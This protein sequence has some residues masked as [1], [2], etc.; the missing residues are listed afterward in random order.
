[1]EKGEVLDDFDL[2]IE[3]HGLIIAG[4]DTTA[5]T[6]SY[7]IWAVTSRPTLMKQLQDEVER[8]PTDFSEAH[9]EQLPILNA[10]IEET[11]RLYGAA[12]GGLPRTVPPAGVELGGYFCPPGTTVT[13][14]A[15]STHRQSSA[16]SDPYR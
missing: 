4:S 3:A 9:V 6:L 12:P 2:T 10:V 5:I 7:L 13:T 11:F 14:Q 8:L 15:Y 16:F 1:V